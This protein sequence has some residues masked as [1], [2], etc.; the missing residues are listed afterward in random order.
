MAPIIALD[1][2]TLEDTTGF[3]KR[4]EGGEP[5]TVKIGM[6]LF[7]AAGPA[8]IKAVRQAHPVEIF[9]DLKLHDI[10]HT[11]ERAAYQL[12]R[13]GVQ[14]TTA[15]AAGGSAMLAA[16]KRGLVAGAASQ[17][18]PAPKLLAITQLTS[19]SATMMHQELQIEGPVVDSVQHL[20]AVAQAAGADGVVASAQEAPLIRAITRPDFLIVTPGI[21]PAGS[22]K[23]DQVRITTPGQAAQL[24]SSA[25]VVG[26]P[27]TQAADPVLAYQHITEEWR[28]ANV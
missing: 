15:H 17:G 23:G 4:F 28:H 9:L 14:L 13:L 16:A 24:G 11:V 1:F 3:L 20:A 22:Q 6:E 12:G 21:R 2:P 7:Y 10:P 18:L 25:I 26:R 5:L 19:T 27:I 8:A